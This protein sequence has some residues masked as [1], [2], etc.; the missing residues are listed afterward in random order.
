MNDNAENISVWDT[1]KNLTAQDMAAT[2]AKTSATALPQNS[3]NAGQTF[4][5]VNGVEIKPETEYT[6]QMKENF[7]F[8]G[9]G[10]FLYAC[11]Y[12]FCMYKNTSGISFPFFIA[13]S[14]F[15]LYLCLSKLEISLKKG[16]SF[17]MA[18]IFL[19][20]VSTFCTDD[21]RI[22]ALNKTGIFLLIISLLLNQVYDTSSWKLGRYLSSIL[23]TAVLSIGGLMLPFRDAGIFYRK[24]IKGKKNKVFFIGAGILAA[25]PIFLIIFSLLVSADAV[26]RNLTGKLLEAINFGNVFQVLVMVVFMFFASYCILAFLCRKTLKEEVSDKRT[27]EPVIAITITS[28]LTL[29]Y[30]FFSVIQIVYL[31]LGQM[32][33]PDGYTYA[34]YAREG[35]FQLLAVSVLNLVIV[36]SGMSFFRESRALKGVLTVMSLCTFIMIASS[37]LRMIIYIRY[38]YLTFLRIFVLWS[39]AVLFLLFAGVVVSIFRNRFPLFRYSVVVVTAAFLVLSFSHPDYWI[40][41]VNAA[42]MKGQSQGDFFLGEPYEDYSYLAHLSTDAAPVL[43]PLF[44]RQGFD[45]DLSYYHNPPKY[46]ELAGEVRYTNDLGRSV[47]CYSWTPESYGYYYLNRLYNRT[48]NLSLRSFNLSRYTALKATEK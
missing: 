24:H 12:A 22:I 47:G 21:G 30:L 35:F 7:G 40:A 31:F 42:N 29:L 23:K 28:L 9:A 11:L 6:R 13:G 5:V 39:L 32:Q 43:L 45:M 3:Q 8:F 48:K 1:T 4:T 37:A 38:Y 44:S 14:L 2:G 34:K 36:L 26:F 15:Y 10:S 33:L 46:D 18:G 16:S 25:I 19:L 17:Y 27:G 20:A 41:R